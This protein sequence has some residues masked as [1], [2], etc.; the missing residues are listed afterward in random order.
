AE[1]IDGTIYTHPIGYHGHGAGPTIGM[2]DS[3]EPRD[4]L[5]GRYRMNANTAFSI[6]L[7]A[8]AAVPEWGGQVVRFMTEEDAFFDGDTVRYLDGRQTRITLVPRQ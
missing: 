6:E 8:R 4:D 5:R 3:Q 2:W 7:N 1:G